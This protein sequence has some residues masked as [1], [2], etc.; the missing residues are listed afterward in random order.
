MAGSGWAVEILDEAAFDRFVRKLTDYEEAVLFAA[1]ENFL[2]PLG[3]DICESEWGKA[4]GEGLYEFR[5]RRSLHA[6]Y[7]I[8]GLD[9]GAIPAAIRN[10]N[11]EVLLRVFCT[12][13]GDRIV[14]LL[15]G[16]NKK[17]DPSEKRQQREIKSA[18]KKLANWKRES[19]RK[20]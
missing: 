16:Y 4:L 7:T 15:A 3:Q 19:K 20:S 5:V 2:E 10:P 14:L 17:K 1:I 18:R 13:H 8:A 12:F 11:A 6:I 9:P